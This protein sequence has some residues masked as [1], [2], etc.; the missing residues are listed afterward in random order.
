[1]LTEYIIPMAQKL[2]ERALEVRK[3]EEEYCVEKRAN[4]E[5]ASDLEEQLT[6]VWLLPFI[7]KSCRLSYVKVGKVE[8][9]YA[10]TVIKNMYVTKVKSMCLLQFLLRDALLLHSSDLPRTND[11]LKENF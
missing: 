8:L 11:K 9:S 4:S 7:Y 2:K 5:T 3:L 1:M 6:E 10:P